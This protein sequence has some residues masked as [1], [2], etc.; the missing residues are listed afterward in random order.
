MIQPKIDFTDTKSAFESYSSPELIQSFL[1]F[2]G[3][4]SQGLSKFG[5]DFISKGLRWGLPIRGL[6]RK[7]IYGHFCG[8]ETLE[9]CQ[10]AV[11]ELAKYRIDSLLDYAVEG[12]ENTSGLDNTV[13]A[14]LDAADFAGRSNSI[15]YVVFKPSALF[16]NEDL[17]GPRLSNPQEYFEGALRKGMDRTLAICE[18]AISLGLGVLIDA[19]QTWLQDRIDDI[20][21]LLMKKYNKQNKA[22]IFNTIQAYRIDRDS[23]LDNLL[24]L[25]RKEGFSVGIK[26]VR[27]AYLETERELAVS[28]KRDSPLWATK[29]ETD[30]CYDRCAEKLIQ[31]IENVGFVAGTHNEESVEKIIALMTQLKI[32]KDDKRV[33]FSQLYG[34]SENLSFVL[35]KSGYRVA[36]YVPYGP[37]EA[38]MPY[39]SR[40][41][42][43]NSSV[44]GQT[45]RELG[46]IIRELKRRG[47][48]TYN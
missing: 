27:G 21:L 34:M 20:V 10:T 12:H 42:Q 13:A 29:Q 4:S 9:D 37:I 3:L 26:L 15:P 17:C 40:R 8:G 46:L 11:N 28:E 39:L 33:Y 23:Y 35:A 2:K 18:R 5:A 30:D 6:V 19:E 36:K 48:G 47:L 45:T 41:A 14:I 22:V 7:T 25:G 24:E 1:L 16:L 44:R 32:S 43:E 38:T 31:N